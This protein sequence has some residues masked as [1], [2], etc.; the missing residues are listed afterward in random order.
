M[1]HANDHLSG[2]LVR[3]LDTQ[4]A[5]AYQALRLHALRTSPAAFSSSYADEAERSIA[6]IVPRV[7][8]AA[9][10][11]RCLFG[12]FIDQELVGF[13]AFLRPERAKLSHCAEVAGMY[14]DAGCRQRGIGAALL[15]AL[16]AHAKAL[17]VRQLKLG[18]N[19]SNAA[20]RQLYESAG[21]VCFG[22]EPDALC[23]DG[24]YY[25]EMHYGLRLTDSA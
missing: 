1:T 15:Q 11:S 22:T 16:V 21:F 25:D 13:V 24:V 8:P 4:D 17:G 23:V 18:V 9:D 3:P 10:G 19:R 12:A 6:E 20:A 5:A 14:V 7:R 2:M